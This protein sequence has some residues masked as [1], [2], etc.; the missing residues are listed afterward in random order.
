[1]VPQFLDQ[2]KTKR[3]L[4]F[5][6]VEG[7]HF[8]RSLAAVYD[9]IHMLSPYLQILFPGLVRQIFLLE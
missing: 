2:G 3:I 1:M 8:H 6:T 9:L 7:D 5:R 4:A